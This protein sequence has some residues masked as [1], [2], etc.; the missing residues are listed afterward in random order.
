M[1]KLLLTLLKVLISV[2]IVAY[3]I[4]NST[5]SKENANA[6]VNLHDQPKDWP[7]FAAALV[8]YLVAVL[9]SFVRWWYLVRALDVPLRLSDSIRIGF[10][11][12]LFNLAPLGI[13]GGDIVKTVMLGHEQPAYRAKALASVLVD[14]VIGLYI[15][16]VVVFAAIFFTGFWRIEQKDI[17]LVCNLTY[18]ITIL[19]TVGLAVVMGPDWSGGRIMKAI[20]RIPRVGHL[21]K[22]VVEAVRLY[23]TKPLVLAVSCALTVPIHC[24]IA[25]GCYFIACGL[26]GLHLSLADHFVVIPLS[27]AMGVI[28]LPFGP[29]EYMLDLLYQFVAAE[30]HLAI[31]AG[32]GFV[33]ALAFRLITALVLIFGIPYYLGNRR[34]MV[35]VMH[36]AEEEERE[37]ERKLQEEEEREEK[38]EKRQ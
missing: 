2:A 13:V 16:F 25:V 36:E 8:C 10:W 5:R 3:L 37:E 38:K 26:R 35:E 34:E 15:L 21:L 7:M 31:A 4:W 9:I 23:N 11:G 24:L 20:A 33:V 17:R 1:K 22:N 18:A 14:R 27:N 12:Y 30:K 29:L 28:P 32:Q 19:S 6:F